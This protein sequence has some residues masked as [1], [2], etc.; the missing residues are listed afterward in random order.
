IGRG[1]IFI[2]DAEEALALSNVA[3]EPMNDHA[4]VF[5]IR[6]AFAGGWNYFIANRHGGRLDGWVTLGRPAQSAAL[7]DPMTGRTGMAGIRQVD[8]RTQV[9]LQLQPGGSIILRLFSGRQRNPR[10]AIASRRQVNEPAWVYWETNGSPTEI[11]GA[12]NVN[13]VQGG[14]ELPAPFSTAHLASWADQPDPNA[15]RFAGSAEYTIAFDAPGMTAGPCFLNLGTVCQSARVRLN[16]KD[17][18]TLIVPPFGVVVDNLKPH[19]NKLEVEATNV[20]ANRIRDL[21]RRH[22]PWKIFGDIGIVDVN[23]QPFDAS[24][25]PLT[26]SGLL[27]PVTLTPML[28]VRHQ[29]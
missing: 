8:G 1:R 3:R 4:G 17:Y 15:Q 28:G 2:G 11:T 24:N 12:W 20:S 13:F 29:Q 21:D 6:R 19:D 27:G 18:G 25:W 14:P 26:D 9:Y 7:M 5:Y 23:Y 16:G 22:V 10:R